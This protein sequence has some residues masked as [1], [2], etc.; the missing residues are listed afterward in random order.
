MPARR[1][2][3]SV[4]SAPAPV[5]YRDQ[6]IKDG[7]MVCPHCQEEI[8]EKGIGC[9]EGDPTR[10]VHGKCGGEITLRPMSAAERAWLDKLTGKS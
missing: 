8:H 1:L 6:V 9:V 3:E 2:I 4:A 5:I 10:S 7:V